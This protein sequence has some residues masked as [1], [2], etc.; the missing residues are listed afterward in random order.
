MEIM[1][2]SGND[3]E[4][5]GMLNNLLKNIFL[6][7]QFWYDLNLWDENYESYSMV[8]NREIVSNICVY[9]TQVLVRGKPH[10]ALSLGAVATK[11]ECRRRGLSRKLMEHIMDK[12]SGTPM[13]LWANDGVVGFYPRFGFERVYEKQPVY[14]CSIN[15]NIRPIQLSYSDPKV[16]RYVYGR[17]NFSHELDCLNTASIN[18]F[19]IH[20]GYLKESLFEIPDLNTLVI[21]QQQGSVLK[22]IGVF[23]LEHILFSD[24]VEHL[25]FS[26]VEKIKFGFMPYWPDVPY[27]MEEYETDPLFVHGLT[28][29]LGDFKFPELSIT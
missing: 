26:N 8:D 19:H 2:C 14:C 28:C 11:E 24:L 12:Y 1:F 13:Y 16:W 17:V 4:Y 23:S 29:N 25:P 9:K 21:A 7:F 6:D 18:M 22:L 10:L 5:Q 20:W 15:N 27:I 3:R